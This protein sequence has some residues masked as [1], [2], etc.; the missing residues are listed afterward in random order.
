MYGLIVP[1]AT[2]ARSSDTKNNSYCIVSDTIQFEFF[3]QK[4]SQKWSNDYFLHSTFLIIQ[5]RFWTLAIIVRSANAFP[6]S[7]L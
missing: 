7:I 5:N 6:I 2:R 3:K 1:K 4:W